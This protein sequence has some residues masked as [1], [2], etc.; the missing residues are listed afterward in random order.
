MLIF[1]ENGKKKTLFGQKVLLQA[2]KNNFQLKMPK[3]R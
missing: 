3:F 1:L 2:N